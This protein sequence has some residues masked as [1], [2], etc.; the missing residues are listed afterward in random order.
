MPKMSRSPFSSTPLCT[1]RDEPRAASRDPPPVR[2][3]FGAFVVA[4]MDLE[5][6]AS[7]RSRAPLPCISRLTLANFTVAPTR[8]CFTESGVMEGFC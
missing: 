6:W 3:G 4:Q 1:R 5:L 7:R 8:A 2:V